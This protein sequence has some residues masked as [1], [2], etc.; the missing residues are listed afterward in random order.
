MRAF[1]GFTGHQFGI[2]RAQ[3]VPQ[4]NMNFLGR[5][6]LNCLRDDREIDLQRSHVIGGRPDP[7]LTVRLIDLGVLNGVC[8]EV[9]PAS[10]KRVNDLP[11]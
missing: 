5:Y 4:F 3:L 8:R 10:S 11:L 9:V 7:D 1:G 2:A 6:P